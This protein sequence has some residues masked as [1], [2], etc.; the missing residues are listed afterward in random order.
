MDKV[1]SISMFLIVMVLVLPGIAGLMKHHPK[2]LKVGKVCI[3]GVYLLA[4]LYLTLLSRSPNANRS[5][6]W[7]PFW[8]YMESLNGHTELGI[9]IILNILLYVPLGYLL[10]FTFPHIRAWQVIAIG[11]AASVLTETTQLIFKLGLFE[12]D[13]MIDN[14]LGTVIGVVCYWGMKKV[15]GKPLE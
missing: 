15:V 6:A 4:N 14:T 8:S 13:D 11:C 3:L 7:V 1:T 2:W 10:R 5:A 9:Q 12:W